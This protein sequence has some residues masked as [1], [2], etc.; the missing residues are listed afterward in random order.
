MQE[1]RAPELSLKEQGAGCSH[2]PSPRGGRQAAPGAGRASSPK[3]HSQ[4]LPY[5][6]TPSK[7]P[8]QQQEGQKSWVRASPHPTPTTSPLQTS[9]CSQSLL[10]RGSPP[11]AQ[12]RLSPGFAPSRQ[13]ALDSSFILQPDTVETRPGAVQSKNK[14]VTGTPHIIYISASNG[15]TGNK[16]IQA[17]ERECLAVK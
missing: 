2:S 4:S 8:Q 13:E 9:P 6:G 14:K 11:G 12:S 3:H 15:S 17:L 1:K 5:F 10:H 7:A 16:G